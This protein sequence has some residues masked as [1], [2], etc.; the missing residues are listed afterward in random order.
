MQKVSK[1]GR[2]CSKLGVD[3]TVWTLI[4]RGRGQIF[5]TFCGHIKCMTLRYYIHL[6]Y[7]LIYVILYITYYF[8]L[9]IG[10]STTI[11]SL[12]CYRELYSY[13]RLDCKERK[14][15]IDY[16]KLITNYSLF[17]IWKL[18][19]KRICW[20]VCYAKFNLFDSSLQGAFHPPTPGA[21]KTSH[22]GSRKSVCLR[23]RGGLVLL[24]QVCM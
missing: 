7:N 3:R 6:I 16:K 4:E 1:C 9:F 15:V 2:P 10:L 5:G 11:S 22:M 14:R 18:N 12:Y 23:T 20:S 17:S 13:T 24:F 21:I 8:I 19:F